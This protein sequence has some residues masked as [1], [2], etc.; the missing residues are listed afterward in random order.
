[1]K[2]CYLV[3]HTS[4]TI[5]FIVQVTCVSINSADSILAFRL[6]NS[7]GR[8]CKEI[9]MSLI[10]PVQTA[11]LQHC[12]QAPIACCVEVFVPYPADHTLLPHYFILLFIEFVLGTGSL[13]Y[14]RDTFYC[15]IIYITRSK[16]YNV[17]GDS[18]IN[19]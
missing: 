7:P 16:V 12:G 15:Q 18:S 1:M 19:I 9:P 14:H 2:K 11:A 17:H 5:V 10:K 8:M 3:E 4:C 13:L 6:S